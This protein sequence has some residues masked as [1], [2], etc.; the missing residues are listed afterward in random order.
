MFWYRTRITNYRLEDIYG[1]LTNT[2]TREISYSPS[3][4]FYLDPNP[5]AAN[6]SLV[7][8]SYSSF[9]QSQFFRNFTSSAKYTNY[10]TE[11]P[12]PH[13]TYNEDFFGHITTSAGEITFSGNVTAPLIW[14]G[15]N[16][17]FANRTEKTSYFLNGKP[18]AETT[19]T[20]TW[21]SIIINGAYRRYERE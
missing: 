10:T 20:T 4:S 13:G 16:Q 17:A 21:I 18:Y 12:Y 2:T 19:L 11:N 3:G 14:L 1:R 9:E 8:P 5:P 6:G 7:Y 15:S